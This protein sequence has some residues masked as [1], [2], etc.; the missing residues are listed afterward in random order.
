MDKTYTEQDDGMLLASTGDLPSG[1]GLRGY[2]CS[3]CGLSY[4]RSKITFF[5]GTPYG[6]PCGCNTDI[7][8]IRRDER[9][10]PKVSPTEFLEASR[11]N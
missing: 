6:I 3:V 4:V 2:E 9:E 8:G 1:S 11:R 5:R 7:A 10:T